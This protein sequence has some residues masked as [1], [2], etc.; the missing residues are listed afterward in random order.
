[1]VFLHF[2][3]KTGRFLATVSGRIFVRVLLLQ[4]GQYTQP[5]FTMR[6]APLFQKGFINSSNSND[7]LLFGI[8][9]KNAISSIVDFAHN[10]KGKVHYILFCI[11]LCE[12]DFDN[13]FSHFSCPPDSFPM[14]LFYHIRRIYLSPHFPAHCSAI[15]F[16]IPGNVFALF[17][18]LSFPP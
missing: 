18:C 6:C 9:R 11:V 3:Q 10:F 2:G 5:S 12:L 14:L 7:F 15:A 13:H 16:A 1:M 17:F 8:D 4:I